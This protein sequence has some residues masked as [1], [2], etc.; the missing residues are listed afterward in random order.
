MIAVYPGSFDP[1]TCGHLDIIERSCKLFDTVYVAVLQNSSKSPLFSVEERKEL[2]QRV[3]SHLDNVIIADFNGL[4]VDFAKG[5]GAK[6]IVKGLRAVSD[7]EYEF[8]MA[9]INHKLESE[10]ETM[11]LMT[12]AQNQYLSSSIV[13]DVAKYGSNLSGLVPESIMQD[14]YDKV[15]K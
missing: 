2:L 12:S 9:L 13:K 5:V 8:Q 1:V 4:L 10:I 3:T 14:I 7:F 11:F 6:I 15:K